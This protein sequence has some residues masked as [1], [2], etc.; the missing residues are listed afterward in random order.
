MTTVLPLAELGLNKAL[1]QLESQ[2]SQ[3]FDKHAIALDGLPD[4]IA[5]KLASDSATLEDV[6]EYLQTTPDVPERL[7]RELSRFLRTKRGWILVKTEREQEALAD[8]AALI[9]SDAKS[10]DGWTLRAVA[11]LNSERFV[12]ACQSFRTAFEFAEEEAS[13]KLKYRKALIF[14]WSGCALLW[15]L[16]GIINEDSSVAQQ[17]AIEYRNLKILAQENGLVNSVITPVSQKKIDLMPKTQRPAFEELEVLIRLF[18]I[19]DPFERWRELGKEISKV[20][21]KDLSA[22]D[23]IREQRR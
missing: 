7:R 3:R 4:D 8:A 1:E 15:A 5:S 9:E 14:G 17:A 6:E 19:V 12:E 16:R 13:P 21:P 20:W 22:V 10:V 18:L 2:W 23:A 11:L